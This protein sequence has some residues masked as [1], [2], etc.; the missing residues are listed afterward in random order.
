MR[1]KLRQGARRPTTGQHGRGARPVS[2]EAIS[3]ALY[4]APVPA[5]RGGQPSPV[6]KFV[7]SA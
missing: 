7:L 6:C 5:G 4:L 2:V 1:Q 3:W